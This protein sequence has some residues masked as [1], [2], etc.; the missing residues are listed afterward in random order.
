M[1]ELNFKD[2][3]VIL[4]TSDIHIEN[5]RNLPNVIKTCD[6]ISK[7]AKEEKVT[8]IFILGDFLNSREKLDSL[9]LN[10]ATDIFENFN[11]AAKVYTLIGNHEIYV[12]TTKFDVNSL[13]PFIRHA[14][15]IDCFKILTGPDFYMYC[16]PYIESND[17]FAGIINSIYEKCWDVPE[18]K[19]RIL[20]AHQGIEGAVTN[21]LYNIYDRN[22][23]NSTILSKFDKVFL[24]HY[25][26]YQD[27]GNITYTG[28]PLQ[29]SFGEEYSDKGVTLYYTK[30]NEFKFIKNPHYECYKTVIN[31]DEDVNGKFVRYMTD[32]L[33][34]TSE[35]E[36]IRKILFEKGAV[37]VRIDFKIKAAE[38]REQSTITG[39][40]DLK[41]LTKEYISKNCG[42]L[43]KE[44]LFT[45]GGEIKNIVKERDTHIDY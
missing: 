30:T 31:T 29:L 11:K 38:G 43:D 44:K 35:I 20:C 42:C 5:N 12:K 24:G 14:E 23:I 17:I 10:K 27:I 22:G 8:D 37:E 26:K 13:K 1:N 18:G 25:H 3:S 15:I 45:V 39:E 34:D 21:D 41:A 28:S 32:E 36:K 33:K 7:I 4:F 6:W 9:A 2:G 16:I 19:K 40:L